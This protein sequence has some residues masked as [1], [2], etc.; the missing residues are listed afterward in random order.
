MRISRANSFPSNRVWTVLLFDFFF[1][2]GLFFK[3]INEGKLN[4]MSPSHLCLVIIDL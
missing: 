3:Y 1:F 2:F 4:K